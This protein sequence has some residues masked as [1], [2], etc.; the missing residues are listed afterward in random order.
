MPTL[1]F[2][3]ISCPLGCPLR[4]ETG[5]RG[6]VTAVTGNTCPRG[7]AYA[8]RE[9]TAPMR[10]VTTTV[11]VLGGTGPVI[12]VRT[13]GQVPKE[14][15]FAVMEAARRCAVKAPV[16]LGDVLLEDA[17]GTGVALVAT[18]DMEEGGDSPWGR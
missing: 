9:A 7:D 14:K 6:E 18:K 3:C 5:G 12:S 2:I 1:E 13:Q 11:R 17:G 10:T 8:R 16:S 4:V 15:I